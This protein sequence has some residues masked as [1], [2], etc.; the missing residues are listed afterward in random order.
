MRR[1]WEA[2]YVDGKVINEAQMEWKALPKKGIVRLT[3]HFDGREWHVQDKVAYVQKKRASMVPG[4]AASFQVESRSIGYYDVIDG[5]NCKV[6][7]TV[8]EMSG[9]MT[10]EVQ[11]L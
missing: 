7:Y 4:V 10:M 8:D 1:G 5:K 2:E 3:L 6:W 9:R 11:N